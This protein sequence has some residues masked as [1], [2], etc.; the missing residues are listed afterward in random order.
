MRTL[1]AD[2]KIRIRREKPVLTR[3][4][5]IKLSQ[6]M[7][8]KTWINDRVYQVGEISKKTGLQKQPDGTWK[9]PKQQQKIRSLKSENENKR[10]ITEKELT[11]EQKAQTKEIENRINKNGWFKKTSKLEGM[12]PEAAANVEKQC[13]RIFQE[14]PEMQGFIEGLKVE[15]FSETE[16]KA[17]AKSEGTGKS[18]YIVF[19]KAYF[20]DNEALKQEYEKSVA[21]NYHPAGTTADSLVVHE[22][23]HCICDYL[24]QKINQ[25][26]FIYCRDLVKQAEEIFKKNKQPFNI[27][28]DLAGYCVDD[29]ACPT[30]EIKF[31]EIIAEA[32]EEYKCSKRP[33]L[34]A[35]F[36]GKTIEGDFDE[37]RKQK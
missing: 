26:V 29:V 23:A 2:T 28:K 24:A 27:A 14:F 18:A 1:T 12:H 32:F 8:L 11:Q 15:T 25:D 36:I 30:D 33:R 9:E 7:D 5:K 16:A 20:A 3:D 10:A 4:T 34:I 22:L 21:D 6:I 13:A 19:N 17:F 31:V 35:L 37:L